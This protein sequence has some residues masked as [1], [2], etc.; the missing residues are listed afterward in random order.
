MTSTSRRYIV[1]K[2][3]N[4]NGFFYEKKPTNVLNFR[5]NEPDIISMDTIAIKCDHC[6][7][8]G[9]VGS[10]LFDKEK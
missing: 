4:G 1:C 5:L 8:S 2:H 10:Y 6:N 7:G 9:H 3:C